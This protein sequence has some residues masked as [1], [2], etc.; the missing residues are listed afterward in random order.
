LTIDAKHYVIMNNWRVS[1]VDE[2]LFG[3]VSGKLW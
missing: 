1:K 2:A 3:I